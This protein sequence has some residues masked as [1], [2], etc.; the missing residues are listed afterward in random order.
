MFDVVLH[1]S[2]SLGLTSIGSPSVHAVTT[3]G[4]IDV[5]YSAVLLS[6][7]V[8]KA[9]AHTSPLPRIFRR[10]GEIDILSRNVNTTIPFVGGNRFGDDVFAEDGGAVGLPVSIVDLS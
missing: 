9:T 6:L 3:I 1:I 5:P 2:E 8:L 7:N 10:V 4:A